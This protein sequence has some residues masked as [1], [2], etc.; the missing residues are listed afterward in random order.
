MLSAESRS[1]LVG[2]K[3]ERSFM[4]SLLF[5]LAGDCHLST[6]PW[7]FALLSS[8]LIF[9]SWAWLPKSMPFLPK[10]RLFSADNS[11]ASAFYSSEAEQ[12]VASVES[13]ANMS[14]SYCCLVTQLGDE[15]LTELV[16]MC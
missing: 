8:V 1:S 3:E 14:I 13:L 12:V 7:C 9:K 2:L 15:F 4:T 6:E 11:F 5:T 16:S 10:I